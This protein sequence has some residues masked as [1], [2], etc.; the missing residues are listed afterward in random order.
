[1]DIEKVILVIKKENIVKLAT[2]GVYVEE[3]IR[4]QTIEN[5]GLDFTNTTNLRKKVGDNGLG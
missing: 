2:L 1:M 3:S 4:R 5:L